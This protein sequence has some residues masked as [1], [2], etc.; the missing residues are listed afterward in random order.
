LGEQDLWQCCAGY[1]TGEVILADVE[2]RNDGSFWHA[3]VKRSSMS[4]LGRVD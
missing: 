1:L 2:N 3:L 4:L